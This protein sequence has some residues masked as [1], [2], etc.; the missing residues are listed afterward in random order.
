MF[1]WA[2]PF[3]FLSLVS[4][5][6]FPLCLVGSKFLQGW[7]FIMFHKNAL[8]QLDEAPDHHRRL[9][10]NVRDLF[11]TNQI[12]AERAS[13][14]LSDAHG[15]GVETLDDVANLQKK[16][17][18]NGSQRSFEE[19]CPKGK[20][21]AQSLLGLG[22]FLAAKETNHPKGMGGYTFAS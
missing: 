4:S 18:K 20:G 19:V 1:F 11:L 6:C 3:S 13:S 15:A 14:L 21:L 10:A 9:R 5:S 7:G 22:R 8:P 12:S 2:L 17:S 16:G